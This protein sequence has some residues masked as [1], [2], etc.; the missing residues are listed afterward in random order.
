MFPAPWT[1]NG[2]VT[3]KDLE[4]DEVCRLTRYEGEPADDLRARGRLLAATPDLLVAC[5][6]AY[7]ALTAPDEGVE[8]D[9][10]CDPQVVVATLRDA[11]RKAG[12][13]A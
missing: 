11:L 6:R 4:G 1:Y 7:K 3:V 10:Y 13:S 2:F 8:G 9:P 5:E 12:R